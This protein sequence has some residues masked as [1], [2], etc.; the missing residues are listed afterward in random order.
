MNS[1]LTKT[2]TT[3]LLAL[4]VNIL[5]VF[6]VAGSA[7]QAATLK[8]VRT[9]D[10]DN[11]FSEDYFTGDTPPDLTGVAF[12]P[13]A[14]TL[15]LLNHPAG[16]ASVVLVAPAKKGKALR[17]PVEIPDSINIAFDPLS[18]GAKGFDVSRLF[19][20]DADLDELIVIRS[21]TRNVMNAKKIKRFKT[22]AF[23]IVD[24]QGMTLD[25][26]TGQLFVLDSSGP[27]LIGIQPKKDRDFSDAEI[28]PI[29]LGGLSGK[30]RGVAYNPTDNAIY[31][32]GSEQRKLYQL[33]L[34]G[35]LVATIDLSGLDIPIPQGM[36]FAP[37]LDP[38]DPPSIFHLYLVDDKGPN[39]QTTE[40]SLQ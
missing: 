30:L 20:L 11:L 24:P 6:S 28:T 29:T 16:K 27:R 23:G 3:V 7:A 15:I 35:E 34:G 26:V 19:L 31:V 25:P 10:N 22:K 18:E 14:Q 39:G 1:P 38:T 4:T 36:I 40:W 13:K 33:T 32:L 8:F 17:S 5:P 12:P 9:N 2:L 37:S 21:G